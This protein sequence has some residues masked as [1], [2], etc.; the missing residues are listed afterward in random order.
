MGMV[1]YIGRWLTKNG[2]GWQSREIRS[3]VFGMGVLLKE[4]LAR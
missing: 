4:L 2:D 1:G 3:K